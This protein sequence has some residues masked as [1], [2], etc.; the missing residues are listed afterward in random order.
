MGGAM[1]QRW[2]LV[3]TLSVCFAGTAPAQVFGSLVGTVRDRSGAVIAGAEIKAA[4]RETGITY[5]RSSNPDGNYTFEH[6]PIG[7]Y[8]V[9]YSAPLFR[10]L[11][12]EGIATHIASVLRQDATLEVATVT[13]SVEVQASTPLVKTETAEIG[14]LIDS[15][16]VTE[17]PLNGRDVLSL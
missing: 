15:R 8:T 7:A 13:G 2:I 9:T 3:L 16:Q 17:L 5:T 12:V 6:L 11:R 10:E 1:N 14:Q 4:D